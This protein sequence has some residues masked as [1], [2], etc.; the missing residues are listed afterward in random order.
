[1]DDK[2]LVQAFQAGDEFAFVSL[3]NRYKTRVYAFCLKMLGDEELARDVLQETFV[4]AYENKH[5]LAQASSFRSWLFTIARNQ[6]LNT[7]RKRERIVKLDDRSDAQPRADERDTPISRLEK[8]ERIALVNRFLAE[9][10]PEYREVII[11]REYQNLSYEEIAAVTRNTVS[12]VKSRL[13]K[14]RRKL[15]GLLRPHIKPE[16]AVPPSSFA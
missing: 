15:A 5:R 2:H 16:P 6:S 4:R 1:M 9:L 7:I 8:N 14:A 13:F 3:Y 12:S 10:K 11:L